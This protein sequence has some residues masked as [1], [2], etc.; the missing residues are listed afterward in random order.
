[1]RQSR[2]KLF[3]EHQIEKLE[4]KIN[5]WLGQEARDFNI[6]RQEISVTGASS[7]GEVIVAAIWYVGD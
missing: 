1:M 5:D 3:A 7:T 4:Q 2:V 6:T